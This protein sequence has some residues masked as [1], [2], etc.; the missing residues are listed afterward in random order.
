MNS[1]A[2]IF[3]LLSDCDGLHIILDDKKRKII[4]QTILKKFGTFK[5][6]SEH[7]RVNHETFHSWIRLDKKR[8]QPPFKIFQRILGALGLDVYLS[9]NT[10]FR[11]N[12]SSI[13]YGFLKKEI[14]IDDKKFLSGLGIFLAEGQKRT[15]K[16]LTITNTNPKLIAYMIWWLTTYFPIKREEIYLYVYSPKSNFNKKEIVNFY[17]RRHEVMKKKI[18]VYYNRNSSLECTIISVY[19]AFLK[20]ALDKLI[21]N[22]ES[23]NNPELLSD[24][25]SGVIIG[26]GCIS[27][28]GKRKY[29]EVEIAAGDYEINLLNTVLRKSEISYTEKRLK[30]KGDGF[31]YLIKIHKKRNFSKLIRGFAFSIDHEKREKLRAAINN[32][33]FDRK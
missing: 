16:K 23:L 27:F 31:T 21:H 9:N 29:Y 14:G 11:F 26:D 13:S 32:Y 19:N 1:G 17:S 30:N 18:K 2:S 7:I 15:S 6:F 8:R 12:N 28:D 33:T 5:N 24:L 4:R 3:G 20:A 25:L 22:V 10:E